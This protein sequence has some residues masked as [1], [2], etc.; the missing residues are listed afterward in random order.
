M[1]KYIVIQQYLWC[2]ENGGGIEY[3]S[4]FEEF[5]RRDKAIKRGFKTQGSD[6]FNIGVIENGRLISFDWMAKP[7]SESEESLKEIAEALGFD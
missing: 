7:V 5:D 2:N 3:C 6:D 4:D 1:P